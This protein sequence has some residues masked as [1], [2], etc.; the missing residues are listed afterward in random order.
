MKLKTIFLISSFT[1]ETIIIAAH[2]EGI[3]VYETQHGFIGDN[4][5]FYNSFYEFG[6]LYYPDYLLSFGKQEKNNLPKDFIFNLDR[7]L[8]IG[9][10]FLE[11]I[12]NT[13]SNEKLESIVN[14]Y[15]RV[16]C[17][18]LQNVKEEILLDWINEQAKKNKNWLFILKPRYIKKDYSKYLQNK[19]C[20]L[21]LEYNIY[22]ILKY[23]DYNITIYSTTAV[24]ASVF[25]V[26]TIF[27]NI[28]GLSTKY[29]DVERL[30]ASKVEV[31]ENLEEKHLIVEESSN[32][33]YFTNDYYKNVA[34]T[35]LAF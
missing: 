21:P 18:T 26:K 8:P 25:N 17:V 20:I 24:E 13:Y 30:Y 6:Q 22:E 19:N 31:G 7:I 2:L 16:F 15:D 33:S 11:K 34:N 35:S 5:Q 14:K 1:K 10:L 28:D 27:Y 32:K 29:F 4:H 12:K 3:K 23:S 9:S